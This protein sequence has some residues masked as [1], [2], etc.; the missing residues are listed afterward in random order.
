M[1]IRLQPD[2]ISAFWDMI[3]HG[4]RISNRQ[5]PESQIAEFYNN[6]LACLMSGSAQCW[7]GVDQLEERRMLNGMMITEIK[8]DSITRERFLY[9]HTFYLYRAHSPEQVDEYFDVVKQFAKDN[10]CVA[11][12]TYTTSEA[13]VRHLERQNFTTELKFYQ[14]NIGG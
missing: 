7:V 6:T 12:H 11:I 9:H 13:A 8:V 4:V 14:F 10:N 3:K 1:I 5:V 2:Q